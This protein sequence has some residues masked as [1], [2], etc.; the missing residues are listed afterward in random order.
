MK[1]ILNTTTGVASRVSDEI[2]KQKT[3]NGNGIF[4]Y[5]DKAFWK[6]TVRDKAKKLETQPA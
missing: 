6:K 1:T 5:V 4:L 3:S 2:A